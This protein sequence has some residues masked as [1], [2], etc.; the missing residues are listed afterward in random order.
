MGPLGAR[1]ISGTPGWASQA[2]QAGRLADGRAGRP[3]G[4]PAMKI[5]KSDLKMKDSGPGTFIF[6][7]SAKNYVQ[8]FNESF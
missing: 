3:A 2:G 1:F 7:K 6:E 8:G 5:L 4:R